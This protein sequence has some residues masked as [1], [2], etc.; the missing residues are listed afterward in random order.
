L[1]DIAR[2][3]GVHRFHAEVL[4]ENTA[5]LSVFGRSGFPMEK[6]LED[7]TVRVSLSLLP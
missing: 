2:E 5:M 1:A 4:P 6:R 7:G 3:K